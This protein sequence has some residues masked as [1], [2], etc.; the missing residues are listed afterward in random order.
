LKE[1]TAMQATKNQ[2]ESELA[3]QKEIAQQQ[4]CHAKPQAEHAWLHKLIGEWAGEGEAAMAPGQPP[5]KWQST[6]VVRSMGGLWIVAE[7]TGEMP[8]GGTATTLLTLG[9]DPKKERY[10]GTFTGSMMT[11]L[12]VYSGELDAGQ[13]VMTL[14]TEGPGMTPEA[15]SA[16]YKDVIELKSDD[17]R[18]LTSLV[19]GSDGQW[20]QVMT[21]TYRRKK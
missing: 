12:W 1:K 19:L 6:E 4:D 9:Y 18:T 8:G 21:A 2:T 20:Q 16:K 13:A 17:H 10:V 14:D 15:P 11:H 5:V 3:A 7:G